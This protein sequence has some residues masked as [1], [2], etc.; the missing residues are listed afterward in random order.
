MGTIVAEITDR[1]VIVGDGQNRWD[2]VV[3]NIADYTFIM[4]RTG[5]CYELC[6]R[7]DSRVNADGT[8]SATGHIRHY[9]HVFGGVCFGCNGSG[10]T[11]RIDSVD[12]ATK[13]VKSRMA[14]KASRARAAEREAEA[15]RVAAQKWRDENPDLAA[16]VAEVLDDQWSAV[17]FGPVRE[18]CYTL[19]RGEALSER[20]AICFEKIHGIMIERRARRAARDAEVATYE[21]IGTV[22]EKISAT[23]GIIT[24][25]TTDPNDYGKCS[26][27]IVVDT[28]KAFVKMTTTALWAWGVEKGEEITVTG[29]VKTHKEWSGMPQTIVKRPKKL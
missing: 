2:G 28:G 8:I 6:G 1:R 23:G 25:F 5:A 29:T 14:G 26:R 3:V 13:R 7:C 21:Y 11:K 9:A 17:E 16:F 24:A 10:V 22:D 19:N 12:E 27:I 15:K 4:G 20:Q 18:F